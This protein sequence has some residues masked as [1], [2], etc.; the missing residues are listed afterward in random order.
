MLVPITPRAW[1]M[2]LQMSQTSA[3]QRVGIEGKNPARTW[4]RWESGQQEPPLRVV[5]AVEQISGGRVTAESWIAA[6]H[7]LQRSGAIEARP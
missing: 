1:R 6:R 3:A 2:S 5:I 4:Q 7:G